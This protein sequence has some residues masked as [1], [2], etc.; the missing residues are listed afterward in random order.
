MLETNSFLQSATIHN[1]LLNHI[2]LIILLLLFRYYSF[3][4]VACNIYKYMCF[5]TTNNAILLV[6]LNRQI[7][8]ISNRL[9]FIRKCLYLEIAFISQHPIRTLHVIDPLST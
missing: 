8:I 2:P 7:R 6:E 9:C 1:S 3:S 5:R 4:I